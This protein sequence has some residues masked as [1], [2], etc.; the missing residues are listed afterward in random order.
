M[1]VDFDNHVASLEPCVVRR[2]A[3]LNVS[4]DRSV[5]V[6]RSL[7]LLAYIR[8]QVSKAKPPARFA[9]LIAGSLIFA[10]PFSHG[11]KSDGDINVLAVPNHF[12]LNRVARLLLAH[13]DLKFASITHRVTIERSDYVSCFQTRFGSRRVRLNLS[14][15]RTFGLLQVEEL[16]VFR[17]HVTDAD[18]HVSV[19]DLTVF[20]QCFY[21]GP[22]DLRRYG[23]A[24]A[25]ELPVRR[26][27]KGVDSNH[28]AARIHQRPAGVS[29]GDCRIRLAEFAGL[30]AIAGGG[31]R[32]IQS[33]HDSA[34]SREPE[35]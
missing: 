29:G 16:R 18:S 27:Q 4:Y 32:P 1:P 20:D 2:T 3:G 33:P 23:E 25:R 17:S 30:A 12:K 5:N 26:D 24:H 9:M 7:K 15:D 14:Y 11:F 28:F 34:G 6:L 8:S 35:A 19:A 22:H 13:C 21:G 10:A 31:V